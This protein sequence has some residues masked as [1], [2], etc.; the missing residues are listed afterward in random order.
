MVKPT[1]SG[2]IIDDLDQVLITFLEFVELASSTF[3]RRADCIKGPFLSD[4]GI[5]N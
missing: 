3:F 1:N 4:L 5:I 2:K